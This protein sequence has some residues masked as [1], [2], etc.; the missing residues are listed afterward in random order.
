MTM[1]KILPAVKTIDDVLDFT[2][3]VGITAFLVRL[4]FRGGKRIR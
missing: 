4:V 1:A 2:I 3:N